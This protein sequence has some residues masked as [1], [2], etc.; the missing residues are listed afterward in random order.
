MVRYRNRGGASGVV[1]YEISDEGI[2]VKF[3]DN[4]IYLYTDESAGSEN[5]REMKKLAEAG[6]G[7]NSF[8]NREVKKNYAKKV[9]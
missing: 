5:I 1:G 4:M 8:I 3:H 6:K 7:L 9:A 2:K